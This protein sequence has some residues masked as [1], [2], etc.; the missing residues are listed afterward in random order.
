M[1][2]SKALEGIAVNGIVK[3][4]HSRMTLS[5]R[6]NILYF[7]ETLNSHKLT[8]SAKGLPRLLVSASRNT[9]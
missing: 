9:G 8:S 6:Q 4:F 3:S 2:L 7:L 5:E 1:S